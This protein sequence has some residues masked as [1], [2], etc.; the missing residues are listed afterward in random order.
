LEVVMADGT[1]LS[2]LH[3]LVKNNTGYNLAQ[4]FA[5][6]EGT[7]GI[8]TRVVLQLRPLPA[9]R[10]TALCAL[11]NFD[12]VV[13]LLKHARADLDGL[14]AI[15]VMWGDYFELLQ[16]LEQETLFRPA[17]PMVV[18]LECE[19]RQLGSGAAPF[20][21]FLAEM[22]EREVLSDALIAKSTREADVFWA[23]REG[24]RLYEAM[25]DLINLDVSID[26]AQMGEFVTGC[27]RAVAERFPNVR[28]LFYGHA[29]D[30]NLHI[31]LDMPERGNADLCHALETLIY[32]KVRVLGGS[33]SAEHGI[34]TLK[35]D[36][37]RYS[38]SPAEIQV[39]RSIK[40]ALDPQGLMNPGKVI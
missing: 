23:V 2:N 32:E 37:L 15:E 30:G 8:I 39:M 17:P 22:L 6:S 14:S 24:H 13:R 7:L 12:A 27:K 3:R 25:P 38:R 28:A 20:E 21:A 31:A 29:G 33:I 1:I 34:G 18:V 9:E 10:H 19:T 36:Y 11:P 16:D 26:I 40:A 4:L 5:G 35:R